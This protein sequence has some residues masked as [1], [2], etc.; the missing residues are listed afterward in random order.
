VKRYRALISVPIA[1]EDDQ[2]A[3][4][5]AGRCVAGI[6]DPASEAPV[7]SL[8]LVGELERDSLAAIG[9]IVWIERGFFEQLPTEW[10]P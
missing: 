3:R 2:D 10:R 7:A 6:L 9:R 8:E 5:R 1:A 4:R